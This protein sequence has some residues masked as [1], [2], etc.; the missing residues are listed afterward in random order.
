M[1]VEATI[2]FIMEAQARA[3]VRAE[4]ADLRM[5][6]FEARME[7]SEMR[8]NAMEKRMDKRMDAIATLLQQGMR[9]LVRTEAKLEELATAQK[10]TDRDLRALIKNLRT[11]RNGHNGR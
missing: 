2:Q 5:Q 10:A 7:K 8:T 11:G 4:K 6:K 1:D 9:I 3:E